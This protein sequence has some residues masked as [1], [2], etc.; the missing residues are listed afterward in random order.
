MSE[1]RARLLTCTQS[2]SGPESPP[3]LK[4]RGQ[5]TASGAGAEL[6]FSWVVQ[7]A[8]WGPKE[9]QVEARDPPATPEG[10]RGPQ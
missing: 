6:E 4:H 8:F 3:P 7:R 1:N 5:M 2:P 9:R 10:I